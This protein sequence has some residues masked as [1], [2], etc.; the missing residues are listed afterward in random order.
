M[1]HLNELT[2][3]E[4]KSLTTFRKGEQKLGDF[5]QEKTLTAIDELNSSENKYVIIGIPEDIGP[6]ANH[7][8]PGAR[9]AWKNFLSKF[10]NIQSNK[11][12]PDNFI[13]LGEINCRDLMEEFDNLND[14]NQ[15]NTINEII[16]KLDNRVETIVSEIY[17]KGHFPIVI[18]GGHN[19]SYPLIS[20]LSK[21]KNKAINIL[22]IDP[23]ADARVTYPRHSGN[24]FSKAM[25]EKQ[26]SYYHVWGLHESYNNNHIL[27]QSDIKFTSYEDI[28]FNRIPENHLDNVLM[29]VNKQS[30]GLEIDLDSIAFFPSSACSPEGFS[31]REIRQYISHISK[32]QNLSYVHI[33]EGAPDLNNEGEN[34]VGKSIA[35]LVADIL[36]SRIA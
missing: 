22:N 18:G 6:Q 30:F 16:E 21:F 19:N 13:L 23:H 20:S 36:K 34:I 11:F 35:Y 2:T 31:L 17:R 7:G 1:N 25:T 9:N 8:R 4:I 14:L 27:E 26:L 10:L 29:L 33:C 32:Y 28:I 15:E 3:S 12:L 24:G 5:L